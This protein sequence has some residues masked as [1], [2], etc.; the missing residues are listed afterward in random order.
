[1]LQT[2]VQPLAIVTEVADILIFCTGGI[3]HQHLIGAAEFIHL[4][5]FIR[6]QEHVRRQQTGVQVRVI[7]HPC[8][9]GAVPALD[10]FD[11]GRGQNVAAVPER[12]HADRKVFDGDHGICDHRGAFILILRH[13]QFHCIAER[14]RLIVGQIKRLSR[15]GCDDH[16]HRFVLQIFFSG[17]FFCIFDR[18]FPAF[19]SRNG[20][21]RAICLFKTGCQFLC[22]GSKILIFCLRRNGLCPFL[23]VCIISGIGISEFFGEKRGVVDLEIPDLAA[24]RRICGD[25]QRFGSGDQNLVVL[26]LEMTI[27]IERGAAGVHGVGD[28]HMVPGAGFDF[29]FGCQHKR[30]EQFGALRGDRHGEITVVI[31]KALEQAEMGFLRSEECGKLDPEGCGELPDIRVR[32]SPLIQRIPVG[33]CQDRHR[34]CGKA[35]DRSSQQHDRQNLFHDL[36]YS[37]VRFYDILLYLCSKL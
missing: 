18:I 33:I 6:V 2:A 32:T 30:F 29:D 7:T 23:P 34:F 16:L 1:M 4:H 10:Q 31:H 28:F 14:L 15:G 3:F 21:R 11:V 25:G 13:D 8:A 20:D 36:I 9:A 22:P 27:H 35:Q 17:K 5:Q 24:E 19:V 26:H 12:S 37:L